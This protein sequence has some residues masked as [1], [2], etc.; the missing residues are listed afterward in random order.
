MVSEPILGGGRVSHVAGCWKSSPGRW[1]SKCKSLGAIKGRRRPPNRPERRVKRP[2]GGAEEG[3]IYDKKQKSVS[4]SHPLPPRL[5]DLQ[6]QT[7]EI[8]LKGSWL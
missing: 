3:R 4:Q 8:P 6:G 7:E 2:R 1:N 5:R